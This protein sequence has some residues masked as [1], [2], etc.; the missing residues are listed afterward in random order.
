MHRLPPMSQ[1]DVY[2]QEGTFIRKAGGR[3]KPGPRSRDVLVCVGGGMPEAERQALAAK[4]ASL[5]NADAK[6]QKDPPCEYLFIGIQNGEF[7]VRAH[8]ARQEVVKH[9]CRLRVVD[10][11]KVLAQVHVDPSTVI[12]YSSSM[13]FPEDDGAPKRFQA[14][15]VLDRALKRALAIGGY[16]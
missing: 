14:H 12:G 4:I 5:L 16:K 10:L 6:S 8:S 13:D 7:H 9:Q 2:V 11:G 3:E 1:K 15:V